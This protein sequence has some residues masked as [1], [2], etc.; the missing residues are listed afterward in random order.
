MNAEIRRSII[1]GLGEHGY[2]IAEEVQKRLQRRYPGH[3]IPVIQ[4]IALVN[5]EDQAAFEEKQEE[6]NP[7]K[8]LTLLPVT[9]PKERVE[10]WKKRDHIS[11]WLPNSS[12]MSLN[13]RAGARLALLDMYD[14]IQG[15][16]SHT[17]N[18][19]LLSSE[20]LTLMSKQDLNISPLDVRTIDL[21]MVLNL[22]EPLASGM[23][24]D[25]AYLV[26]KIANEQE[27][28][29]FY[30]NV[31]AVL[32]L[33][34]E[35]GMTHNM[36]EMRS[37]QAN[38]YAALKELDYYMNGHPYQMRYAQ[39]K[40][41]FAEAPLQ[42][43][44]C[45]L[46]GQ[47]NEKIQVISDQDS[48]QMVAEWLCH[49]T[50][51]PIHTRLAANFNLKYY[52]FG[53]GIGA[54]SSF[55]L[56]SLILPMQYIR[57][58]C[59]RRLAF[60]LTKTLLSPPP[61][62]EER[63]E[64]DFQNSQIV[65]DSGTL[66]R[67]LLG[68]KK[69]Y[70]ASFPMQVED[71]D[72]RSPFEY[73][74]IE[75]KLIKDYDHRLGQ[76]WPKIKVRMLQHKNRV[77][78][79]LLQRMKGYTE[80]TFN[81]EPTIALQRMLNLFTHTLNELQ[82]RQNDLVDKINSYERY[83]FDQKIKEA[84]GQYFNAAQSFGNNPIVGVIFTYLPFIVCFLWTYYLVGMQL[85][86]PNAAR[87]MIGLVFVLALFVSG[88][89][90]SGLGSNK[91][92]FIDKYSSRLKNQ[93]QL[94]EARLELEVINLLEG[95]AGDLHRQLSQFGDTIRDLERL[96]QKRWQEDHGHEK[97][98]DQLLYGHPYFSLEESVI[99]P[100]DVEAYYRE[101]AGL[102]DQDYKRH[103]SRLFVATYAKAYAT[104]LTST[105]QPE[106]LWQRLYHYS[107]EQTERLEEHYIVE[108]IEE[109]AS[110]ELVRAGIQKVKG[111]AYPYLKTRLKGALGEEAEA[112]LQESVAVHFKGDEDNPVGGSKVA[113]ALEG[114]QLLQKVD[115]FGERQRLTVI[116]ARR[117][118][119]LFILP[120]IVNCGD[121]Y[122]HLDRRDLLHTTP[123][124][125]PLPDIYES[126][127]EQ[128]SETEVEFTF[129]PRQTFSLSLAFN[130]YEINLFD[131]ICYQ[132][133]STDAKSNGLPQQEGFHQR[134]IEK[135]RLEMAQLVG[136]TP[137]EKWHYL[138]ATKSEAS[139]K[140]FAD[141]DLLDY[142]R[143][144]LQE[145]LEQEHQ[146][147]DDLARFLFDYYEKR[148][149]N[150][151]HSNPLHSLEDWER[152]EIEKAMRI[153]SNKAG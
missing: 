89:T 49:I 72:S 57:D 96:A 22:A 148:L 150:P 120:D 83:P 51:A 42:V 108:K 68:E 75:N 124:N 15:V 131:A 10:Y 73:I 116:T 48:I 16:L 6:S 70:D 50:T 84:R 106:E 102:S 125:I 90:Y 115:G 144:K 126:Y 26:K 21:F 142:L 4:S 37:T 47:T 58:Y 69:P 134:Y 78:N 136:R 46:I 147:W 137:E 149:D 44:S 97:S 129:S 61:Q 60:D 62:A 23:F 5:G 107:S 30:I 63:A 40:V 64:R 24:I 109:R 33:P 12:D 143:Q 67:E 141:Q 41:E 132:A 114:L 2:H 1:I 31:N 119:P 54:Y 153:F 38:A 127:S 66:R 7:L 55:G 85:E 121:S 32:L 130:Q 27:A 25:L 101:V 45:Y 113:T 20:S 8:H 39:A 29:N 139:Q 53:K 104:W 128:E 151:D 82:E 103:F 34:S 3:G 146:K 99:D 91:A 14:S 122:R 110:M 100:Q 13:Y 17:I 123:K 59:A 86:F 117:G 28:D 11:T 9:L 19:K 35:A 71:Y 98:W 43:G 140:L 93:Q 87:L 111:Y 76:V 77:A 79:R 145:Y 88:V 80:Q 112:P 135:R 18:T 52:A 92:K 105:A 65:P 133:S 81:D 95:W 152:V 118:L 56:S 74:E 36:N 94:G 138:G